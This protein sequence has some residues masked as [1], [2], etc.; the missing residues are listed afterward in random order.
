MLNK[1][2]TNGKQAEK[3]S[4][5][6]SESKAIIEC[7]IKEHGKATIADLIQLLSLSDGR[8]RMILIEMVEEGTV[9][10]VGKTKYAYYILKDGCS[11]DE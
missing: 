7:F 6:T 3:T 1:R 10:K 8:I 11:G 5:K 2:K 9:T 4:R